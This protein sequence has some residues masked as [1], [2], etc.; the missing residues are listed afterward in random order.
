MFLEAIASL[1]V[2]FS[3]SH[4]VTQSLTERRFAIFQSYPILSNPIQSYPILSNPF[5]FFP[6]LANPFHT[7]PIPTIQSYAFMLG[8]KSYQSNPINSIL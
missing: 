4:S 8:T 6:I 5:Q 3:L 1:V 2:T 7:F